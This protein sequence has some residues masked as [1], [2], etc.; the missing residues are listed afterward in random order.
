MSQ[1]IAKA[2][3]YPNFIFYKRDK[4]MKVMHRESA[5]ENVIPDMDKLNS[6]LGKKYV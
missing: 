5:I 4:N 2:C 1:R 6:A 3:A